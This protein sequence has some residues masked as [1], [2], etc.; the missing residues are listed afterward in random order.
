MLK[1]SIPLIAAL[2]C[3]Y[4]LS[5]C[6]KNAT[7]SSVSTLAGLPNSVI[8]KALKECSDKGWLVSASGTRGGY[9]L[10]DEGLPIAAN[11]VE[12]EVEF[13]GSYVSSVG[14]KA[15]SE[16][17]SEPLG[18]SKA[19]NLLDVSGARDSRYDACQAIAND[20]GWGEPKQTKTETFV[21]HTGSSVKIRLYPVRGHWTAYLY[22]LR[23]SDTTMQD[24]RDE[25]GMGEVKNSYVVIK[26]I[27]KE[28]DLKQLKEIL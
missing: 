3:V 26:E 10:T 25:F 16:P 21:E 2:D 9:A 28:I 24:I 1:L 6:G 27:D 18:E 20:I 12:I 14:C 19:V 4:T 13:E 7:K 8:G 17:T 15:H 11:E 5:E 22:K 23:G